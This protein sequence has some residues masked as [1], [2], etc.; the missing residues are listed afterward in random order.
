L[1]FRKRVHYRPE[2][3]DN[4]EW[5]SLSE[6]GYSE[7]G[8]RFKE[9]GSIVVLWIRP[10]IRD[11][12]GLALQYHSTDDGLSLGTWRIFLKELVELRRLAI[13]CH[14]GNEISLNSMH[15]TMSGT[16]QPSRVL[17]QSLQYRLQI[18]R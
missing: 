12:D 17:E 10:E 6:Q 11:V 4:P 8:S 1:F 2:N 15:G 14:D 16:A 3:D 9:F 13:G 5:D 7:D 18:E